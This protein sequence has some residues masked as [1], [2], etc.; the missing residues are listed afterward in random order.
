MTDKD[1]IR[2]AQENHDLKKQTRKDKKRIDELEEFVSHEYISMK[3]SVEERTALQTRIDELEGDL[4]RE[5][6]IRRS[7]EI[8]AANYQNKSNRLNAVLDNQT[9]VRQDPLSKKWYRHRKEMLRVGRF[10]W[11]VDAGP[12][13]TKKDARNR[14]DSDE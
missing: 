5:S 14:G 9:R 7:I 8:D 4:S 10:D 1:L 12:F 11:V 6:D 3:N 2:L 13:N